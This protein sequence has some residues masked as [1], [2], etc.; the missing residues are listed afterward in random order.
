MEIV[1]ARPELLR[2]ARDG[3]ENHLIAAAW[4]GLGGVA[5]GQHHADLFLAAAAACA[6]AR[7][8]VD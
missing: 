5:E 3:V 1:F 7:S 2:T 6:V 4:L 8:A